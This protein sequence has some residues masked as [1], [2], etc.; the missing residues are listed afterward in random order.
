MGDSEYSPENYKP[1]KVGIEAIIKNPEML[2][3]N[4][5]HLMTKKMCK[6]AVKKLSFVIRYVTD[7]YKNQEMCDKVILENSRTLKFVPDCCKN[8]KVCNKTVECRFT[9]KR[10]RDMIIIY[11]Q[12]HF[13]I[14]AHNTTQSFGQFG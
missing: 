5:D 13:K 7:R 10:V 6:N 1:L 14:S 4:L 11:S 2:R 8:Q 12:M 3:F 9:L